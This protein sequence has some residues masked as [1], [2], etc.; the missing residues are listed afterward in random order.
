MDA[1]AE[2]CSLLAGEVLRYSD[3][4]MFEQEAALERLMMQLVPGARHHGSA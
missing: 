3:S 2:G 1:A 4:A